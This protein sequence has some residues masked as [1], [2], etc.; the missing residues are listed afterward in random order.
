MHGSDKNQDT[1][2]DLINTPSFSTH[3]PTFKIFV[4]LS[5]WGRPHTLRGPKDDPSPTHNHTYTLIEVSH[6]PFPT[7]AKERRHELIL[8]NEKEVSDKRGTDL[9]SAKSNLDATESN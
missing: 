2:H 8:L 9:F 1:S 5:K 3:I 6:D 4:F 7:Q